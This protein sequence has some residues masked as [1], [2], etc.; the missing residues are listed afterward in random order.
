MRRVGDAFRARSFSRST[1]LAIVWASYLW[2]LVAAVT[3]GS[4]LPIESPLIKAGVVDLI[5]TVMIFVISVIFDNS[6]VYDPYWSAAPV[7]ITGYW[8][9]RASGGSDVEP[10][11]GI[12]F[13]LVAIWG[14]RLTWNFLAHWRGLDHEDWRYAAYRKNGRSSYWTT[15]LFGF[16]LVP[17]CIVFAGCVPV[18]FACSGGREMGVVDNLAIGVTATAILIEAVADAQMRAFCATGESDGT[19]FR[20]GLW[21]VSRHPNYFGEILFW[22]GLYLFSLG[23]GPQHWWTVFGPVAVTVL[24]LAVS[25]PLIETRMRH[26]RGDYERVQNEIS[27]LVPWFPKKR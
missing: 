15:S 10:R 25:L 3:I 5:A 6:S 9:W 27:G 18:Y 7:V 24:F 22:W 12:V 13:S 19:T 8:V 1:G 17:T 26:R 11:A 16:H 4:L 20:S 2:T 14:I 21:A 23:A